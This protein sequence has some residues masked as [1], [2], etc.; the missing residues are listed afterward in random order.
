MAIHSR[1]TGTHRVLYLRRTE[2][3]SKKKNNY[4]ATNRQVITNTQENAKVSKVDSVST[5]HVIQVAWRTVMTKQENEETIEA[6]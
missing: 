5:E 2:M 3:D 4:R 6:K 1:N